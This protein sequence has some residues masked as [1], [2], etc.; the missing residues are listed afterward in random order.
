[1]LQELLDELS[2]RG[3]VSIKRE[4]NI[5]SIS[6]NIYA[7]LADSPGRALLLSMK[8]HGGY[9]SCPYCFIP[10]KIQIFY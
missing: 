4:N 9:L 3:G 2:G 8:Q 10:G 5:Y 1:L 6:I 7:I